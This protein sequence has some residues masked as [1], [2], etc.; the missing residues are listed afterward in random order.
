MNEVEGQTS[1]IIANW[2]LSIERS[3]LSFLMGESVP[4]LFRTSQGYPLD[5]GGVF[6]ESNIIVAAGFV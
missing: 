2:Q 5:A 1:L 3:V 6:A 4:F